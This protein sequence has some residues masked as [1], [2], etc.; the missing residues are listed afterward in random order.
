MCLK[1]SILSVCSTVSAVKVADFAQ[2]VPYSGTFCFDKPIRLV[3]TDIGLTPIYQV[4][5]R[6]FSQ[7]VHTKYFGLKKKEDTAWRNSA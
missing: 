4:V 2:V 3:K 6:G 1:K 7:S 5:K